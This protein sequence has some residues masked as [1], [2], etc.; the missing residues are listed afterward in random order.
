MSEYARIERALGFLAERSEEQPAL[1]EG[2]RAGFAARDEPTVGPVS[3]RPTA[4][5]RT[6]PK[7]AVHWATGPA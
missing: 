2:P 5:P 1:D 6:S 7:A 3:P 4:R